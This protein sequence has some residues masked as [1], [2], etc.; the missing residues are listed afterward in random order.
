MQLIDARGMCVCAHMYVV[1]VC[2]DMCVA[3]CVCDTI[4]AYSEA[5]VDMVFER[6]HSSLWSCGGL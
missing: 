4:C 6:C 3:I 2:R 5:G 1:C